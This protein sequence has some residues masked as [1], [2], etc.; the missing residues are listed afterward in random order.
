MRGHP[1]APERPTDFFS[2]L[3]KRLVEIYE[4]IWIEFWD[5]Y[6]ND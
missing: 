3:F 5:F 1:K 4:Q 2:K 6:K